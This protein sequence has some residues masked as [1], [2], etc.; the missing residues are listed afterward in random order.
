MVDRGL[1]GEEAVR[2]PLDAAA[3][4]P[5]PLGQRL[6]AVFPHLDEL[7]VRNLY[8]RIVARDNRSS[9]ERPRGEPS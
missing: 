4:D 8:A 9:T 2:E 5:Y 3:L 1:T 7:N 6:F